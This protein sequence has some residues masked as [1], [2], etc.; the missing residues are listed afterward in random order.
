MD[1]RA[2]DGTAG[3]DVPAVTGRHPALRDGDTAVRHLREQQHEQRWPSGFGET[4]ALHEQVS[5]ALQ[6]WKR[7]EHA[8]RTVR[9]GMPDAVP[10]G[11][12][13]LVAAITVVHQ[14]VRTD[15][16]D[17]EAAL[18][19]LARGAG[20]TWEELAPALGQKDRRGAQRYADRLGPG[21]VLHAR[22]VAALS[23]QPDKG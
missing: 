6:V 1:N 23:A 16:D 3:Q 5:L 4:L 9:Y 2:E 15:V 8:H 21:E 10:P 20:V 17:L 7:A 11:P 14:L 13:D 22:V 18:I 19:A 12:V